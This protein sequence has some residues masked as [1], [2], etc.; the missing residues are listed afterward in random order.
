MTTPHNVVHLDTQRGTR[1]DGVKLPVV[2]IKLRDKCA[3]HLQK[4]LNQMFDQ[5]DDTLFG[6]AERSETNNE[7]VLFFDAM[8]ELRLKKGQIVGLCVQGLTEDFRFLSATGKRKA[9]VLF[10]SDSLSLIQHDV[11]EEQVAFD[12]MVKRA[13]SATLRDLEHLT[14]RLDAVIPG[15][16]VEEANNPLG[17]DRLVVNFGKACSCIEIDIKPRLVLF[18]LFEKQVLAQLKGIYEAANKYL[19][20]QGVMPDLR[21]VTPASRQAAGHRPIYQSGQVIDSATGNVQEPMR[22]DTFEILRQLLGGRHGTAGAGA[23][24]YAG[25]SGYTGAG[26]FADAGVAAGVAMGDADRS[27]LPIIPQ[28]ALVGLL[29]GLQQRAMPV[30]GCN[31]PLDYRGLIESVLDTGQDTRSRQLGPLDQDVMNLVSMLFE[32]ILSDRNLHPQVKALIGRLQIPVLKVAILDRTFFSK[33]GHSAR[34]LLNELASNAIGWTE[35]SDGAADPFLEKLESIVT[36]LIRDFDADLTLFDTILEDF[37]VFADS[38]KKRRRLVEQRTRDAEMG[39]AKSEVARKLVQDELNRLLTGY[40]V[41]ALTLNIL[42]QGW[43]S[44]LVLIYLKGGRDSAEWQAA[45]QTAEGLIIGT[46][47]GESL[48]AL[49]M[50]TLTELVRH[51]GEGLRQSA[52]QPFEQDKLLRKVDSLLMETSQARIASSIDL[53]EDFLH[54]DEGKGGAALI[55]ETLEITT[56]IAPLPEASAW[57]DSACDD[58]ALITVTPGGEV[59]LDK[60]PV[61]EAPMVEAP[62]FEAPSTS[63]LLPEDRAPAAA[64]I[65]LV[66]QALEALSPAETLEG[67]SARELVSSLGVGCW[68][69]IRESEDKRYRAKLAAIIQTT[70]K[71]IFVNRMGVKVT[72]KSRMSLALSLKRKEIVLLDDSHLFD[73]ALEAVI[74]NLR[75]QKGNATADV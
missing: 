6:R 4:M 37:L 23:T 35:S 73:R 16:R 62:V 38:E 70:G 13:R 41:P 54:F 29:S 33:S 51:L 19:I 21:S 66:T 53:G 50:A 7:Q 30:Q 43:S 10:D 14:L 2:V 3:R 64:T 26:S 22:E 58:A 44:Y 40:S 49:E 11:L 36:V 15:A 45:L 60:S 46:A 75:N 65:C 24:G 1:S 47:L 17:P 42:H 32:Y 61:V 28:Q 72:E 71:Y 55:V 25:A 63:A 39:K 9:E 74:G 56:S 5:I 48:E 57:D 34:R 12:N 69:E 68:V 59:G 52:F 67:E 31:T 8:R 18:K 20:E 27:G